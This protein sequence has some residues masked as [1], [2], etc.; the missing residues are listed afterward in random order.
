MSFL[1]KYTTLGFYGVENRSLL[2][3]RFA[4]GSGDGSLLTAASTALG[5]EVYSGGIA[6]K[7]Q[8]GA[9]TT[10]ICEIPA[11]EG[12]WVITEFGLFDLDDQLVAYANFPATSKNLLADGVAN[13]LVIRASL[14]AAWVAPVGDPDAIEVMRSVLAAGGT[15][16]NV[17]ALN[18]A[19]F[20]FNSVAEEPK[21]FSS[22]SHGD[23]WFAALQETT[24]AI[25][26]VTGGITNAP[27]TSATFTSQAFVNGVKMDD[28]RVFMV[29]WKS[30]TA[31]IFDPSTNTFST[32]NGV[33]TEQEQSHGVRL[34]DGR[35]FM[36]P[37]RLA[38]SAKIYDPATNTL[39]IPNGTYPT[40]CQAPRLL[41]DGRVFI[42]SSSTL[43]C[44]II[45]DPS[46]EIV[47]IQND[48]WLYGNRG[49]VCVL[50]GDRVYMP[51]GGYDNTKPARIY[52]AVT[53]EVSLIAGSY[54][55]AFRFNIT[56]LPNGKLFLSSSS[57]AAGC[58]V[59]FNPITYETEAV[60]GNWSGLML[61]PA[62]L[63]TDGRVFIAPYGYSGSYT[64][65]D[66]TTDTK[67]TTTSGGSF[68]TYKNW[69]CSIQL[70]DG[71][72]F[73]LPS[74]HYYAYITSTG[75]PALRPSQY[76][77]PFIN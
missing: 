3:G 13:K 28:G 51:P 37:I 68:P 73:T 9:T 74:Q 63:I 60:S 22:L 56:P 2:L 64:V 75:L 67:I 10:Y 36:P 11:T 18:D 16:P 54:P 41:S 61:G 45:F 70:D 49:G 14:G 32:P 72:I 21:W 25:K 31:R 5:S 1:L 30:T 33:Y 39:S 59:L 47:T 40:Y 77:S 52:N 24:T 27:V 46:S 53:G 69:A 50:H 57:S 19:W 4:V 8:S 34:L 35:I 6:S 12:G 65:Y 71:R 20:T 17:A 26:T 66:Y 42:E 38:T 15:V 62:S 7:E 43:T 58:A 76:L 29:P 44:V 23:E 55:D 48:V